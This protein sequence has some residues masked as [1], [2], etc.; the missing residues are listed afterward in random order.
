MLEIQKISGGHAVKD[1]GLIVRIIKNPIEKED[2]CLLHFYIALVPRG[3]NMEEIV[4]FNL[5]GKNLIQNNLILLMFFD[6][7]N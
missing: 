1:T 7:K 6:C 4:H 5:T 3:M 2:Y